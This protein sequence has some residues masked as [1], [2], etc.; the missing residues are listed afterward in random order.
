MPDIEKTKSSE[1]KAPEL[2]FL[3]K[4]G[5][6][7]VTLMVPLLFASSTE[8]IIGTALSFSLSVFPLW[9]AMATFPT[10]SYIEFS[11][12]LTA[13]TSA[14]LGVPDIFIPRV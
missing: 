5:S 9:F 7:K 6:E 11:T 8:E 10:A 14:P 2:S 3:L 13:M 4:T 1:S 12:G